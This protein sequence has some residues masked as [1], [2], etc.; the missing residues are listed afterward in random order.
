MF[1]V[2]WVKEKKAL[3]EDLVV[4]YKVGECLCLSLQMNM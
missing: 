1:S 4:G 3:E 2:R